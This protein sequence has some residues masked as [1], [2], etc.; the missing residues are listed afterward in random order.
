M[1]QQGVLN[2]II[3]LFALIALILPASAKVA[4]CLDHINEKACCMSHVQHVATK[5]VVEPVTS[6]CKSESKA[7]SKVQKV[8]ESRGA[9]HCK[10]KSAP[11]KPLN[12]SV[13]Q[14]SGDN[15][16]VY[17][18]TES[19]VSTNTTSEEWLE[20]SIF[21]GDSSPPTDAIGSSHDGRAPPVSGF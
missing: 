12:E 16:A 1:R 21:F 20:Q 6:C 5:K 17:C 15:L 14:L 10:I 7:D 9:C 13:V 11:T 3:A 2:K 4:S 19:V 18:S 8:E